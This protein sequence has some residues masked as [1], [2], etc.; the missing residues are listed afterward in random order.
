[1]TIVTAGRSPF[2]PRAIFARIGPALPYANGYFRKL[3]NA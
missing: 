2:N 3:A 1:M